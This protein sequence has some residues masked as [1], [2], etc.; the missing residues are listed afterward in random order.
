[1]EEKNLSDKG[2][3]TKGSALSYSA[4]YAL[5]VILTLAAYYLVKRHVDSYHLI[6]SHRFLI[7]AILSLAVIQF[8]VQAVFFLHLSKKSRGRW[9]LIVFSFMLLVVVIVVIGS[10]WIMHNLN[11]RM[12]PKQ[13]NKYMQM[14]NGGI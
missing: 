1:M 3:F 7:A 8:F 4:G 6:Y 9:N 13:I 14:Q 11:Y 2:Q 10:L 5:S 12:T